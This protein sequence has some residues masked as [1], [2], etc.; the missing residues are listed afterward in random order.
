MLDTRAVDRNSAH[1]PPSPAPDCPA[2]RRRPAGHQRRG[3]HA[4]RRRRPAL[5]PPVRRPQ[6]QAART[7]Y[8]AG[9]GGP[10][11]GGQPRPAVHDRQRR[12]RPAQPYLPARLD[13]P[14][15]APGQPVQPAELF[16]R[17]PP[18]S[19]RLRLPQRRLCREDPAG[20]FHQRARPRR[21]GGPAPARCDR[22][23]PGEGPADLRRRQVDR[24]HRRPCRSRQRPER[25]PLAPAR[26]ARPHRRRDQLRRRRPPGRAPAL[27]GRQR[28]DQDHRHRRGVV[29]RQVRRRP[30]VHRG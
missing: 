7:A 10:D 25:P 19:G 8:R 20:R 14:A 28:R 12:D 4:R 30:A 27:Q 16:G 18:G 24:H 13:R 11:R 15:R 5:R 23:G 9:A 22:P 29:L 26:S 3:R 1:A 2:G 21:R 6:R 17:L